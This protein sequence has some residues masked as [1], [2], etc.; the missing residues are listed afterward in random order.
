MS[1][2]NQ[3]DPIS[4]IR[5]LAW[6]DIDIVLSSHFLRLQNGTGAGGGGR[7]RERCTHAA[8]IEKRRKRKK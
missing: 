2:G 6:Y 8:I 3:T 5:L 7:D 4:A 1:W